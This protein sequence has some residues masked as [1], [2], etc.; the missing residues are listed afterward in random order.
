M[1][2]L[3]QVYLQSSE[4]DI[5]KCFKNCGKKADKAS[6]VEECQA[7][8]VTESVATGRSRSSIGPSGELHLQNSRQLCIR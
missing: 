5:E 4:D 8:C 1:F 7:E 6:K 2:Y 3:S